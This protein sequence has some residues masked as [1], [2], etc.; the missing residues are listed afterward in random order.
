MTAQDTPEVSAL[1]QGPVTVL[2]LNRPDRLNALTPDMQAVL[3]SLLR[4]ADDDPGC[5]AIV[6]TGA[7]RAFCAGADLALLRSSPAELG[8]SVR[9]GGSRPVLAPT[10][11]KP[12][13]AAVNGPAVGLG[14]VYAVACDVRIASADAMFMSAFAQL[15][16]VAEYGLAWL[17]QRQVGLARA[18][19]ILLSGRGVGAQEALAIGLVHQVVAADELEAAA[20]SFASSLAAGSSPRSVAAIKAQLWADAARPAAEAVQDSLDRMIVSFGSDDLREALAA[21]AAKRPPSFDPL[22]PAPAAS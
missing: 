21:R 7:G 19:E 13:I 14:M 12:V 15:G 1:R 9:A 16:L 2:T 10:L 11:R 20:M 6:L 17:L 3:D 4:E 5:R 22:P 8:T 18:T